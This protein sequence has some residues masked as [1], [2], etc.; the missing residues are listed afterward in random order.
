MDRGSNTFDVKKLEVS[1]ILPIPTPSSK[2][3]NSQRNAGESHS[4]AVSISGAAPSPPCSDPPIP[5]T[6]KEKRKLAKKQ[7]RKQIRIERAKRV[8]ELLEARMNDPVEQERGKEEE[9]R[10]AERM[11]RERKEF[12]ERERRLVEELERKRREEEEREREREEEE[13]ERRRIQAEK[14]N[15]NDLNSEDE[16]EYVEEGP[17]EII[18]QGN[19][20]IVKKKKVRVP[21]DSVHWASKEEVNSRPISNPLAPQ[22]EAFEDYKSAQ[23]LLEC[24][25]QQVPNFGTEQ[26]KAHCPF[27]L[28]T[29]V[30]RFGTRCSRVHFYPDKSCTLLVKNM[31]G[32]PGLAWEQDEGLEYTDEEVAHSFEDFYEDVHTEFLKFGEILNFKVCTNGS[33]HLRG[34][35]YVHYK[36]LESA[37][38]AYHSINGRYFAGKQI[39]CEF[40]NVTRWKVAICGEYMK[41]RLKNCSRG[42]ACNFIHCFRNPGGDYEWADW[43]KPPPSYWIQRMEALFGHTSEYDERQDDRSDGHRRWSSRSIHSDDGRHCSASR[44][45]EPE[46][47]RGRSHRFEDDARKMYRRKRERSGGRSEET[48]RVRGR[49]RSRSSMYLQDRIIMDVTDSDCSSSDESHKRDR[50]NGPSTSTKKQWDVEPKKGEKNTSIESDSNMDGERGRDGKH[51]RNGILHRDKVHT[52]KTTSSPAHAHSKRHR[53][54]S[55]GDHVS[56]AEES[57][58]NEY[59]REGNEERHR[60]HSCKSSR[61]ADDRA[62]LS[63]YGSHGGN[64]KGENESHKS[65]WNVSKKNYVEPRSAGGWDEH[66]KHHSKSSRKQHR[67]SDYPEVDPNADRRT[68]SSCKGRDGDRHLRKRSSRSRSRSQSLVTDAAEDHIENGVER[69]RANNDYG[70]VE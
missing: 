55:P 61:K 43:D 62:E 36:S 67:T 51:K 52:H 34:N 53:S 46:K 68:S 47:E 26:D 23:Q 65:S 50:S 64:K 41:S 58:T 27:H 6:R 4:M 5:T 11:E 44:S 13:E 3:P 10:E 54:T 16:W 22:S 59:G 49:E 33:S 7:K 66:H 19:E 17:A 2:L 12:E 37:V 28:K 60:K 21:K 40:I 56:G 69:S 20:I 18:W 30:C 25:A 32:G 39:T 14:G 45:K 42:S 15:P 8:R 24:V 38:L 9:R 29:G 31:Y 57:D 35:V 63:R 1:V 48:G 70:L